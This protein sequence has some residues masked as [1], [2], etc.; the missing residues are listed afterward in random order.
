[1]KKFNKEI[2]E[3][4][5]LLKD[6]LEANESPDQEQRIAA[7][8]E[9]IDISSESI[10]DELLSS[11]RLLS[12]LQS[13][14]RG[15]EE[16]D[17]MP[18]PFADRISA[19][20]DKEIAS[21]NRSARI[22]DHLRRYRKKL[23]RYAGILAIAIA[24]SMVLCHFFSDSD[25]SK[26]EVVSYANSSHKSADSPILTAT[27]KSPLLTQDS[28]QVYSA[29]L[30]ENRKSENDSFKAR[31]NSA[32]LSVRSEETIEI[33]QDPEYFEAGMTDE[34]KVMAAANYRVVSD[35]READ[36]ILN[37]VFA[38]LNGNLLIG[39]ARIDDIDMN[40]SSERNHLF[41]NSEINSSKHQNDENSIEI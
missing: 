2:S 11:I 4:N 29:S 21:E 40:Y 6:W 5:Y 22:M 31:S 41:S 15:D 33:I 24:G 10:P 36:A 1:M 39:A 20:L 27:P 26:D 38:Q 12:D 16:C 34:E 17:E 37:M 18:A 7:L 30:S 19:A 23:M 25:Q 32:S 14:E 3:L 13:L 35:F 8:I 28:L 9:V